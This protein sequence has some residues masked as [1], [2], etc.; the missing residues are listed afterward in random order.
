[1]DIHFK[2]AGLAGNI[3]HPLSDLPLCPIHAAAVK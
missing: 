1:M 2:L 3:G